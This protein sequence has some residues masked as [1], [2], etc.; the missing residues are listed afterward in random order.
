MF[1]KL[2]ECATKALNIDH[3]QQS[4]MEV[5]EVGEREK[6]VWSPYKKRL[7]PSSYITVSLLFSEPVWAK[8]KIGIRDSVYLN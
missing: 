3:L 6:V 4:H 1:A 8:H 2:S 7:P 5:T